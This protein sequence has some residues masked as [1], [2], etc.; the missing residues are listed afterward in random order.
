MSF[1]IPYRI[2]HNY[3]PDRPV[4]VE[5]T[6]EQIQSLVDNGYLVIERLFTGEPLERLRVAILEVAKREGHAFRSGR[7]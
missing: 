1:T 6:P 4:Q 7:E 5:A 2:H 3:L